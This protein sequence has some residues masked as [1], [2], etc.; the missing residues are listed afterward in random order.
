MSY[1]VHN[2]K[3]GDKLYAYQ[4]N[5]MDEAIKRNEDGTSQLSESIIEIS[6]Y[7]PVGKNRLNKEKITP[8]TYCPYNIGRIS[9]LDGWFTSD[10]IQVEEKSYYATPYSQNGWHVTYYDNAKNYVSGSL[11]SAITV[12]NGCKYL[13]ISMQMA[14][15]NSAQVEEGT[16]G[17]SYE[18]YNR[19][20]EYDSLPKKY[21]EDNDAMES[22]ISEIDKGLEK[23]LTEDVGKN[24]FNP[25]EENKKSGYYVSYNNGQVSANANF[26]TIILHVV[27][28]NVLSFNKPHIHVCAFSEI[29]NLPVSERGQK[30]NGYIEGFADSVA[31][32]GYIVP[33]NAV[34]LS[35][36][37]SK[38][39][40]NT[41][42][43]EECETSTSYEKYKTGLKSERVIGLEQYVNAKDLYVGANEKYKTIQSAVDDAPDGATIHIMRGVYNEAV[44]IRSTKKKLHLIGEQR[45]L[46]ILT[47]GME[48]YY[49][50]P[51]EMNEG[52]VENMSIICTGDHAETVAGAYCVHIDYNE[53]LNSALQFKNVYFKNTIRQC[54]GIGLREGFRL[55]FV[56]CEF[57]ADNAEPFYCHEQQNDNCT[58][59]YVELID[60]SLKRN[61]DGYVMILQ[62]TTTLNNTKATIRMQRCIAKNIA[63]S[64]KI[65]HATQYGSD[66]PG[67]IFDGYLGTKLWELDVMSVGNNADILNA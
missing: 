64:D 9:K 43:I 62:E 35:V 53:G 45:D 28:G 37:Y 5:E 18:T 2:F 13:R 54:V 61:S 3:S 48:D 31:K 58:N 1:D 23:K 65:I 27:G 50:P 36:S 38:D 56:N 20:L 33:N 42:Q 21:H 39:L 14:L 55:S 12:P 24:L 7:L 57:E 51:L 46:V 63:N 47:H 52:M 16:D 32:Q 67:L 66:K 25:N 40:I 11:G 22:R 29:P 26:E 6:D 19:Y 8:N 4:L 41:L 34:C 30:L 59:Q 10:Y 60:C 17:T 49:T 44:D 15:L